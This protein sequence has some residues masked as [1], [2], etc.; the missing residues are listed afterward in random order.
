MRVARQAPTPTTGRL[1][2]QLKAER[3]DKG[4]DT[5]EERLPIAKQPEVCRFAPEIDGDGAVFSRRFGG[6]AHVSLLDHQVSQA[7]ETRWGERAE[8]S[9]QL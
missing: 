7:E 5:F 1:V 4:E 3:Y 6:C 8:I 9:R 2:F